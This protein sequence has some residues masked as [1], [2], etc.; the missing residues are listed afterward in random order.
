MQMFVQ[1]PGPPIVNQTWCDAVFS[2]KA[3]EKGGIVR[4]SCR[5]VD[6]EIGRENFVRE[7][8]QRGFHLV[9]VGGQYVVICNAGHMNVIC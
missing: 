7:V 9:E 4:R 6:R 8:R 2:A 3:V 5:D 1:L